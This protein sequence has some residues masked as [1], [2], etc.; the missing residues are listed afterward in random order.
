MR[1]TSKATL[2][3]RISLN[4]SQ[5]ITY[6][7]FMSNPRLYN[8]HTIYPITITTRSSKVLI[9]RLIR[10]N[11]NKVAGKST[12]L[13]NK[14]SDIIVIL[15][16][17][18]L[19]TTRSSKVLTL[20]VLGDDDNMVV[21]SG[22][23]LINKPIKQDGRF[24]HLITRLSKRLVPI[25][26]RVNNNKVIG[27]VWEIIDL[28]RP[29]S[30]TLFTFKNFIKLFK[31]RWYF[32]QNSSI[33]TIPFILILKTAESSKMSVPIAIKANNNEII[34]NSDSLKSNFSKSKNIQNFFKDYKFR[35]I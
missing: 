4:Q 14:L 16:I 17:L 29:N 28:F 20:K 26:I 12:W 7:Y 18:M 35:V 19:I 22:V 6:K 10:N 9:P 34:G 32:I 30:K 13:I 24:N 5:Y 15:F 33:I 31:S 2:P 3:S 11:N 23:W 8:Y 25:A 21:D 1:S 27:D